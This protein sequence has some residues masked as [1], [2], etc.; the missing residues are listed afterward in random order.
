MIDSQELLNNGLIPNPLTTQYMYFPHQQSA[1]IALLVRLK[2]SDTLVTFEGEEKPVK[3][4]VQPFIDGIMKVL[5]AMYR[6]DKDTLNCTE[7][8]ANNGKTYITTRTNN[9]TGYISSLIA[10]GRQADAK[11]ALL[12]YLSALRL[13]DGTFPLGSENKSFH[14]QATAYAARA[15]GD[16]LYDRAILT[17]LSFNADDVDDAEAVK[18]A[19]GDISLP[20]TALEN[21]LLPKTGAFG[22]ALNWHSTNPDVIDPETGIV[23]RPAA[24]EPSAHVTL[25]VTVSRGAYSV[26]ASFDI[27]V[28]AESASDDLAVVTADA[29]NLKI[30]CLLRK[31]LSCR[32]KGKADRRRLHG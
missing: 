15:I 1:A 7:A 18:I 3:D 11:N 22:C 30:P 6:G 5:D 16:L 20:E 9:L 31:I 21:L 32:P 29:N 4:V 17:T 19:L 23:T 26:T 25:T 10:V 2:D 24:G 12:N 28:L 14:K 13:E 8:Q 27:V